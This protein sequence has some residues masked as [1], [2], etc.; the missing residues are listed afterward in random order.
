MIEDY[1]ARYPEL[2]NEWERIHDSAI[3]QELLNDPE[4]WNF[5]G[6]VATRAACGQSAEYSV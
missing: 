4:L 3:P 5:T 6:D 1:R 2:Y